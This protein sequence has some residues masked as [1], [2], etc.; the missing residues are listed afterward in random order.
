MNPWETNYM[1][2]GRPA[3]KPVICKQQSS[4]QTGVCRLP[5]A[6]SQTCKLNTA[7]S[8]YGRPIQ[9][10]RSQCPRA[11]Q[12]SSPEHFGQSGVRIGLNVNNT[13]NARFEFCRGKARFWCDPI[14]FS[15]ISTA[16][17]QTANRMY[18]GTSFTTAHSKYDP[19]NKNC[20]K[21]TNYRVL[22]YNLLTLL[23]CQRVPCTCWLSEAVGF[24]VSIA[25]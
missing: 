4:D 15:T 21:I 10:A 18:M 8:A 23:L 17:K 24:H 9:R 5:H 2:G 14:V 7:R 13:L 1:K 22:V 16:C 20:Q 12:R 25:E 6:S 19:E 11:N 3:F